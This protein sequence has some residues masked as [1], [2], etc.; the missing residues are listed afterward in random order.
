MLQK[1]PESKTKAYFSINISIYKL[2]TI[3]LP[4]SSRL[5]FLH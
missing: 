5:S 2:N 4:A 3:R 1:T